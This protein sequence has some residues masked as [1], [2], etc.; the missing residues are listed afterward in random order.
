METKK[1]TALLAVCTAALLFA[2]CGKEAAPE[3]RLP[4]VR[5]RTVAVGG[6]VRAAEYAGSVHGRYE[7]NMAFQVGG[8][9]VERRVQLGDR[10]AAGAV[11]MRI[12]P[13]DVAQKT[14]AAD[15][16]AESARA[17]LALA[18]TNYARYRELYAAQA[19]AAAVLDQY[20]TAYDAALAAYRTAEAQA[21]QAHNALSYTELVA[22]ADGVVSGLSAETGQVVAAGQTVLTFVE[23]GEMEIEINVPENRLGD[24]AVG[25]AVEVSFWAMGEAKTQGVVR[26]IAPMADRA[27]RTYRVRVSVPAPPPGMALGMTASVRVAGAKRPGTSVTLP[28]SA[29]YQTGEVPCVWLVRDGKVTLREVSVES[30][31]ANEALVT[32]LGDGDVVVTAGVHKLHEGEEVRLGAEAEKP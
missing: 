28:L 9:I 12:D 29:I 15:A 24:V 2:G 14:D 23:S 17:Q 20:R 18:E 30:F 13:K 22:D 3:P 8:Q 16:Q 1:A 27:T 6:A 5:T 11:L 26:E 32:G 21:A 19:V 25:K 31:G 4:L 10:V 7:K